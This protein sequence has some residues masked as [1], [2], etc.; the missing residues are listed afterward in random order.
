MGLLPF[1]FYSTP[2]NRLLLGY[3][4]LACMQGASL[5]RH[6]W[7]CECSCL[8]ILSLPISFPTH[9]FHTTKHFGFLH[10]ALDLFPQ[11][12]KKLALPCKALHPARTWGSRGTCQWSGCS[13]R[14]HRSWSIRHWQSTP[15]RPVTREHSRALSLPLPSSS[16]PH[17]FP[18]HICCCSA[19]PALQSETPKAQKQKWRHYSNGSRCRFQQPGISKSFSETDIHACWHC[20]SLK[21]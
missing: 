20:H 15:G 6:T 9:Y 10:L 14:S 19:G 16:M 13:T 18:L 11:Q 17:P 4:L 7:R 1:H 5:P 12:Q 21:H 2:F 8:G 3:G